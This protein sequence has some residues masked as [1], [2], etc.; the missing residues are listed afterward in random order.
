VAEN[1]TERAAAQVD[2]A[3]ARAKTDRYH[4]EHTDRMRGV[5]QIVHAITH[6]PPAGSG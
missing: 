4:R 2:P 6:G 1:I 5:L 3:I